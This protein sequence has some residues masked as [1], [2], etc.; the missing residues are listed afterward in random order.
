LRQ[1]QRDNTIHFTGG[2]TTESYMLSRLVGPSESSAALTWHDRRQNQTRP[3][4]YYVRVMQHNN[5]FAWS[6]PIWVG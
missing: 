6:S 4:W 1:L 3:D 2:F 5:H